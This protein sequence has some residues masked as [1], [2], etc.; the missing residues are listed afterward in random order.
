MPPY[1]I[2][3]AFDLTGMQR[4]N[5]YVANFGELS[6]HSYE[7]TYS[8]MLHMLLHTNQFICI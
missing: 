1:H 3:Y 7:I 5:S 4:I 8:G 2:T 6:L